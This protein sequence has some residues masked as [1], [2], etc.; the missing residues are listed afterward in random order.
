MFNWTITY[1]CN[2]YNLTRACVG[3]LF[4]FSS[5]VVFIV[6]FDFNETIVYIHLAHWV[7]I[8]MKLLFTYIQPTRFAFQCNYCLH[9][10]SPLGLHFN[11]TIVYIHLAH[12]V[13]ISM[14]LLF[15]YIQL[16]GFAFQC[17]YCLHT[18]SSLGLH[19]NETIV[20]IHL[21]HWVCISM[22]LLFTYIQ[23]TG[24]AFQ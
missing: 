3:R 11:E 12:W 1:S 16:T 4:F 14:K 20:Y 6:C 19:F 17:N 2:N 7:F 18:F 24:F 13:W 8:S 15:T 9:T 10:F 21:A 22:K 23:F 5:F